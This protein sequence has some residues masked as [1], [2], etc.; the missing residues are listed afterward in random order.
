[1]RRSIF[2]I[3]VFFLFFSLILAVFAVPVRAQSIGTAV[4]VR[5][6]PISLYF[7]VDGVKY[8]D[9]FAAVWPAGS[10]HTLWI[11]V[12]D[13]NAVQFKTIYSFTGWQDINGSLTGNPVTIT[14]D[15]AIPEYDAVFTTQYAISLNFYACAAAPCPGSPG[16]VYVNGAGYTS[17]TDIY[18]AAG[19]NATLT[20]SANPG[21]VF[22]G[23]GSGPNNTVVGYTDYVVLNG[24]AYVYPIFRSTN[25]VNLATV[26]AGLEVMADNVPTP[27]PVAEQWGLGTTHSV[28]ALTPQQDPSGNWWVFGSW[29]DGGASTHSFTPNS[30][31]PQA[32][33]VTYAAAGG[34]TLVTSPAGL[35]LSVD[36]RSNWPSYNF[37][38]PVGQTHQI[39][40]PAQQL[41]AQGNAWGF[42]SWSNG[43]PA[44]QNYVV[45][46]GGQRLNA[47]YTPLAS[48]NVTSPI[49]GLSVTVD[50]TACATPCNVIRAVG[51]TVHVT[52]PASLPVSAGTR[53]DFLGWP[54]GSG[55]DWIAALGAGQ[56]TLVA[57]YQLM[58]QLTTSASPAN[59]ASW[60]VQP[61]SPD[62]F[63]SAISSVT[64]AV[65]AEP[66]YAFS[67]W[68]GDL[69]GSSPSGTVN[70]NVPRSVQAVFT[71]APYISPAGVSNAAGSTPQAGVAPGSIVT[72]FGANLAAATA[73][74]PASPMAQTLGGVTV[75]A[76]G[77]LL[78]LYFVSPAQIN[79]QLPPDFALGP[80][81][82]TVSATGQSPVTASFT[83][84]QD[85]PGL[86]QQTVNT[87]NYALV[88]HPDGSLVTPDAPAQ[89]GESL[90]LYGTGF[91]PTSTPRL[92]GFAIPQNPAF[93]IVD[94]LSLQIA[95]AAIAPDAAFA[96]PG[97][98]GVDVVQFHLTSA[99]PSGANANLYVTVNGQNS[100]IVVLPVQ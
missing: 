32:L 21:W 1:M 30:T 67:N 97:S 94:P 71:K 86:F 75:V 76:G 6:I 18:L 62:G 31:A 96:L 26:P 55:T 60:S 52:A 33:T 81:T 79:V 53:E 8:Y 19:S 77:N 24:P 7:W 68:T 87:Q 45:P 35:T 12:T 4:T 20:A 69:S 16:T 95:G 15:P 3:A 83:V 41:D 17:D 63:Y 88:L 36:G 48:L 73:S 44:T 74:G 11:Q 57:N 47:I 91:G 13:Q 27:T 80:A 70:M 64:V 42:S 28:G 100:N 61:A 39:S 14:A 82:I 37:V 99:V 72:I 43:A 85:A 34:V 51:A 56:T 22:S 10:Q 25:A 9:N 2:H 46:A 90:T 59:G 54:G 84:V 5:T 40:A 38:W 65:T 93:S 78:P 92:D 66:G 29:S 49:A 58:N 89:Q 50:G 23:W 98:V